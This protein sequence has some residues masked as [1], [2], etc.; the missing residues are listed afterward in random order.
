VTVERFPVEE[1][2]IM[3]FARAICDPNP[4]YAD[5]R[6]PEAKAA[7]GVIAPPTFVMAGSQ[8][9]PEN[10]L[11]PRNGEPW[12]GSGKEPTGLKREGSGV[13]H[14]EQHF[15]YHQPLRAGMVLTTV[16]R[17]GEK[18]EKESKRA[19][20]LVFEE[21]IVEYRDFETKEL[22]VT[23]KMVRVTPERA[24]SQEG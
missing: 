6:T 18:W 24:V 7:G 21:R 8:W 12:F 1:S 3:L 14:A 15:E 20:K 11:R 9:D 17:M 19:G 22:M 16:E 10:P 5:P 13:L 2:H 23:A 4:A